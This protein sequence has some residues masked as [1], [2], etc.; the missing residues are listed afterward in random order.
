MLS[1]DLSFLK[2]SAD[3]TA[4]PAP[5][6][7]HLESDRLGIG[8]SYTC[9]FLRKVG[10]KNRTAETADFAPNLAPT[11]PSPNSARFVQLP[12]SQMKR[13]AFMTLSQFDRGL[14]LG[15]RAFLF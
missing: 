12:A 2:S 7:F 1:V 10:S 5:T 6:V 13:K 4:S 11:A 8:H 3:K 14:L 15:R 9:I